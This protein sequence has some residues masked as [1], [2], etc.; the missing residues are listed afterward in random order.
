MLHPVRPLSRISYTYPAGRI[1][2][3]AVPNRGDVP[4]AEACARGGDHSPVPRHDEAE[5]P[6][7]RPGQ[8]ACTALQSDQNASLQTPFYLVCSRPLE[9]RRGLQTA[10][11]PI[12]QCHVAAV[13]AGH[14]AGDGKAETGPSRTAVA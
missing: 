14:A 2:A 4:E 10:F 9:R 8:E 12:F 11:R 7:T 1:N 13:H 5:A 3:I 6:H